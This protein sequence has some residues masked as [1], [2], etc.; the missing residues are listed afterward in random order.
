ME[1]PP[2]A[3]RQLVEQFEDA[4]HSGTVPDIAVFVADGAA[5]LDTDSRRVLVVHLVRVDLE[6]RWKAWARDPG[7]QKDAV[8]EEYALRVAGLGGPETWPDELIVAE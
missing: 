3:V 4:W 1:T 6:F 7:T 2:K 8:L 5:H